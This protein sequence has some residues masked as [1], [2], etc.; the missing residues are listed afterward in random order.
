MKPIITYEDFDKSDLR[1]GKVIA[2]SNPE[3]S[4][5]LIELKVDFGAEVGERTIF[6]GIRKWH[7]PEEMQGKAYIFVVNMAERK[8]GD[9]ASQGMLIMA[10]TVDGVNLIPVPESI[11]AGT[12]VK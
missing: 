6:T 2:A 9:S 7:T 11:P 1:V 3:W 12:E 8:M 5:K 4:N 10:D